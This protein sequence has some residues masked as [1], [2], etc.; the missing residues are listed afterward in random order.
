MALSDKNIVITPNV[1]QTADPKI[2]FSGADASTGPKNI[3]VSVYPTNNGTL[4]FEGT[5]GQLFS[6]SDSMS[7]TIY[8]VND[9]SGIPS[10][11]VLDTGLI[12]LAQYSGNVI[13]GSAN[14]NGYKFEIT[15]NANII[16]NLTQNGTQVSLSDHTHSLATISEL[17]FIKLEDATIQS[18]AANSVT[19]T[20]S[21][22]YGI[23]VNSSG[24]AVVNVPWTDNNT[25]T[26]N[27][28]SVAGYVAAPSAGTANYVWKCDASGNPAW[29]AEVDNYS[30]TVTSVATSGAITGG[31]ITSTGTISHSTA[32]GYLHVPATS[33]TNNGKVLTA[34]ATAGSLSWTTPTVGTVTSVSGTGTVSGLTLSGSVTSSGSLTLGGA[35][36]G[37]AT[38]T[39]NHTLDALSNTTITSNSSGE[40]LKWDGSAWVNNTLAE[41][42]IQ[43][44][45]SYQSL[46]ATLTA[47]AA[48]TT[49]AD[50]L[51]YATGSDTFSTTTLTA[52]A[53]TLLDDANAATMLVTLGAQ[54]AATAINT[55][56]IGSQSVSYATSAGNAD[57]LDSLHAYDFMRT[58]GTTNSNIDSDWGEG[59]VTFDPIPSGTPPISSPNIRVLN[60]GND[61]NRRTQVA[62]NYSTDQTWFRRKTCAS[63]G[64][65]CEYLHSGN[66]GSQSVNYATSAGSASS[67]T[68]STNATNATYATYVNTDSYNAKFHWSGQSGQPTWLWGS[69]NG[70]DIYVWNPSNF[71]VNYATSAG[72]VAWSG[73]TSKPTTLAGY[74]ITD[75]PAGSYTVGASKATHRIVL[76]RLDIQNYSL[77][78]NDGIYNEGGDGTTQWH[79]SGN[80][81]LYSNAGFSAGT[82]SLSSLIS[83]LVYNSHNHTILLGYNSNCNCDCDCCC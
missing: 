24:Q 42:G 43:P 83:T 56:N 60:L 35:I 52:F 67:A 69:N 11:E 36:T 45:G 62:F 78:Y 25:W 73:V 48:L 34:G 70:S 18:V 41:A 76:S 22:T 55:G 79:Q 46:D 44:A 61:Y 32:D 33:T 1:N 27:A 3:T 80:V 19:S 39:H 28:L 77:L 12:K 17:G 64:P 21:R 57:T 30:G 9:I 58:R 47:L 4:S 16:G 72:S 68:N 50:K 74:G 29:R 38:D 49:A 53:R 2:V 81:Y 5:N 82:Y 75:A 8:S 15:G 51:I 23:Q 31:T 7:G 71:S 14:D 26:A 10:I 63:W 20:A 59:V 65:W 13:V 66:I 37:F 54:A 6:I 40:I